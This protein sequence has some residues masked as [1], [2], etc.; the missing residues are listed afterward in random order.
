[1]C[2][3]N[4]GWAWI[5]PGYEGQPTPGPSYGDVLTIRDK[6]VDHL[7]VTLFFHEWTDPLDEFS[8]CEFR[9]LDALTE[10]VERIESEGAH[11]ELEPEYA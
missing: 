6:G 3:N 11:V 9:P 2:I 7:G 10:Q 8:S 5:E 1:M 4:D